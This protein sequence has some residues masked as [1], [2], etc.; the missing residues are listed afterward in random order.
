MQVAFRV[1]AASGHTG[2]ETP[3]RRQFRELFGAVQVKKPNFFHGNMAIDKGRIHH[4]TLEPKNCKKSGYGTCF[5]GSA[6]NF[7][8]RLS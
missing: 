5:F 4:Y 1:S 8:H 3:T 2:P 6:L 7:V